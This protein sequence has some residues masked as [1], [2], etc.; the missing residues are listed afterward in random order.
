[1]LADVSATGD[2]SSDAAQEIVRRALSGAA[3]SFLALGRMPEAV[4]AAERLCA[5]TPKDPN[6]L[7]LLGRA[8]A[9]VSDYNRAIMVLEQA[10]TAQRDD[11]TLMWLE[12]IWGVRRSW[13]AEILEQKPCERIVWRSKGGTQTVGVVTFHRLNDNQTRVAVQMEWTPE[14]ATEKVGSALKIDDRQVQGDLERFKEFIESRGTETG[15]WRG[16]VS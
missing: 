11:A 14:S 2:P 15:A 4:E 10:C 3:R 12:N 5:I 8:L 1:V 9:R 7:R 6:A 13:E 16:D